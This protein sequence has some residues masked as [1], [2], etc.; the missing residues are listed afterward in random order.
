VEVLMN[1][2]FLPDLAPVRNPAARNLPTRFTPADA[3]PA[4]VNRTLR[5]SWAAEATPPHWRAGRG[6]PSWSKDTRCRTRLRCHRV[7]VRAR[8]GS[9]RSGQPPRRREAAG[10]QH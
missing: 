7:S 2:D 1:N 3:P 9:T 4:A 6:A 8:G 10:T 5:R